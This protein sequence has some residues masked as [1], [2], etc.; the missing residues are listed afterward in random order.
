[1]PV[2]AP[3]DYLSILG[4][5]H[6]TIVTLYNAMKSIQNAPSEIEALKR[7]ASLVSHMLDEICSPTDKSSV[8]GF[9]TPTPS[10]RPFGRLWLRW[11]KI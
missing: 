8:E 11:R 6:S 7:E 9:D 10:Y 4:A 3:G 1:M 5:A 2:L